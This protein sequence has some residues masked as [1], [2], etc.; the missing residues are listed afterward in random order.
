M[1]TKRDWLIER[2]SILTKSL[3]QAE[4]YFKQGST[5]GLFGW[6]MLTGQLHEL[7]LTMRILGIQPEQQSCAD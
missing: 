2:H 5:P 3:A 6:I 7:E 1:T 4:R